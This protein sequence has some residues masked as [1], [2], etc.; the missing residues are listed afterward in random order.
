M[1]VGLCV[2][3]GLLAVCVLL[4]ALFAWRRLT[5]RRTAAL[6]LHQVLMRSTSSSSLTDEQQRLL[7]ATDVSGGPADDD[8]RSQVAASRPNSLFSLHADHCLRDLRGQST[9]M[10]RTERPI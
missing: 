7:T 10:K 9:L 8:A 4:A 1:C 5:L 3:T 2:L 6:T